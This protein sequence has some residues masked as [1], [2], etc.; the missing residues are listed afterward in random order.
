MIWFKCID[1]KNQAGN[2]VKVVKGEVYEGYK[3]GDRVYL[4]DKPGRMYFDWR[5]EIVNK[6]FYETEEE[7]LR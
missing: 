4:K 2:N 1:D 5:F 3:K 7:M 6:N